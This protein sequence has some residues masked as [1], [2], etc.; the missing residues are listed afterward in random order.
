MTYKFTVLWKN[1]HSK[2]NI[3]SISALTTISKYARATTIKQRLSSEEF[4]KIRIK[5]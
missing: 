1:M 5:D 4:S 2:A 3:T